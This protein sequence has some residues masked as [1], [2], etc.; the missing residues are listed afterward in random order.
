MFCVLVFCQSELGISRKAFYTEVFNV[1]FSSEKLRAYF[2][3]MLIN[4]KGPMRIQSESKL[5]TNSTGNSDQP[6]Y[7][8]FFVWI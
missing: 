4:Q 5:T 7:G 1:S 2:N 3:P 6:S 8:W